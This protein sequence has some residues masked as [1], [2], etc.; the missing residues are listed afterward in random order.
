M[1][2]ALYLA[3]SPETAWAELYRA[4]SEY[5]VPPSRAMPRSLAEITVDLDGV[6]DLA[7]EGALE[8][9]GLSKPVPSSSSWPAFQAVGEKLFEDGA[10][11]LVAPSAAREGG[12][13][14]CVFRPEAEIDG[15][16][17][18]DVRKVGDLPEVPRGLRT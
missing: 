8:R 5:G 15:V 10:K 1:V 16:E 11:G 9:H 18:V 14:L 6:E 12:R 2:G 7:S 4:L 3:D 17:V 13:V